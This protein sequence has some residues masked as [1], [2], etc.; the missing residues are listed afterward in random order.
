MS[1]L[2]IT[3]IQAVALRKQITRLFYPAKKMVSV[4]RAIL[5]R[6]RKYAP[7]IQ[8]VPGAPGTG[9]LLFF[10]ATFHLVRLSDVDRPHQP[11]KVSGTAAKR[12][13]KRTGR[14]MVV[15]KIEELKF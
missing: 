13:V 3:Y 11:N 6:P 10:I 14:I 12:P 4:N 5:T 15:E 7:L 2:R 9:F 8:D 1:N